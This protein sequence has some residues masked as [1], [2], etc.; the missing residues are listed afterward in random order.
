MIEF[1]GCNLVFK[2]VF[3]LGSIGDFGSSLSFLLTYSER[4]SIYGFLLVLEA[5]T[6]THKR[7][8]IGELQGILVV[9]LCRTEIT[10]KKPILL[11]FF[12]LI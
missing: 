6:Y 12:T 2:E 11:R 8:T 5:T 4:N 1:I 7:D 9:V 3:F 10:W